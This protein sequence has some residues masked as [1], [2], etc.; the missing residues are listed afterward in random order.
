MSAFGGKADIGASGLVPLKMT[1]E[2]YFARLK[3]LL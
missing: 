2:P 3:S 1:I